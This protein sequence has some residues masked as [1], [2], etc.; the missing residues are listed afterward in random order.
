MLQIKSCCT[1]NKVVANEI[2]LLLIEKSCCKFEIVA[3]N[4]QNELLQ[5]K[6]MLLKMKEEGVGIRIFVILF[7]WPL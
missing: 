7:S 5:F 6:N 4:F 3:A 1:K 2:K